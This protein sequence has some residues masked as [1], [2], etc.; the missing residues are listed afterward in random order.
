M[1]PNECV[2][3]NPQKE[4]LKLLDKLLFFDIDQTSILL[5]K[6][7]TKVLQSGSEHLSVSSGRYPTG[8][9]AQRWASRDPGTIFLATSFT[10]KLPESS[11]S[12]YSSVLMLAWRYNTK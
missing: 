5:V 6:E 4:T 3:G 8:E 2:P 12:M 10:L 7:N 9:T 11:D 1:L